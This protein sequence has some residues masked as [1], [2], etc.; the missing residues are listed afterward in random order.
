MRL[1]S[2]PAA[3]IAIWCALGVAFAGTAD[4]KKFVA[5]EGPFASGPEVTRACLSCHTEAAR[6]IHRTTHWTWEF[7]NPRNRQRLGKKNVI[8]NFCISVGSNY[9][10]C[11]SCHI[12][13]GW[14][15]ESFDFAS[16]ENV[17]CLVCH[18]TTGGYRKRR[19]L[20]G[21]PIY[22]AMEYPPGSG[23]IVQPVDLPSVA[24][25]VGRT[26]RDSCGI[27]HFY[28]GG[29]IG[30]KHGD[31]DTSLGTPDRRLDVHMNATGLDFTCA[32]CH[33]T[34]AHE[35]PGSRYAPRAADPDPAR[36]RGKEQAGS[37]VT[38]PACHGQAPHSA[39]P[40]MN[41]HARKVACQSCHIPRMARGTVATKLTWDWSAA[42]AFG[43]DGRPILQVDESGHIVYD[44]AKGVFTAAENVVPDYV[45]FNGTVTYTLLGDKIDPG[46][47][48]VPINRF[49]GSPDDG[50]SRIW[51]VKVFRAKQPY[52]P[53]NRTLVAPHLAG[54]DDSAFWKNFDWKK[55][56]AAGM[57]DAGAPFS[58]SIDFVST[59]MRWPIT[60]MVAPKEDALACE[61]CHSRDGR[62]REI[63]GVYIPG[64]DR[65]AALD[66]VGFSL[67]GLALLGAIAHGAGRIAARRRR[68]RRP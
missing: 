54:S 7:L 39:R 49:G 42:G 2:I 51:P 55:A 16:E 19:G 58:G 67:A 24:Q 46:A 68:D 12:G 11:T 31:M 13:Y 33:L 66:T 50:Q 62:L 26:S 15:D 47:A 20:A 17:D 9:A 14:R 36:M 56:I 35:V 63:R 22:R 30:V 34:R 10:F 48:A 40:A 25:N 6:Q 37:P 8:N 44:S 5:L 1:S 65:V 28:G 53:V 60:H 43:P 59:E 4:H 45:W 32:T 29:G 52:D 3:A 21:H 23:W 64:R 18:D 61:E 27:C 57:K 38:C 41:H